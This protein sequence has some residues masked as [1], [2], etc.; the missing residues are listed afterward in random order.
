MTEMVL[1]AIFGVLIVGIL[2]IV[3][4]LRQIKAILSDSPAVGKSEA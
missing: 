1:C 3:D 2:F 4:E